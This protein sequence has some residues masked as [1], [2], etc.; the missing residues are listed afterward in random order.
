MPTQPLGEELGLNHNLVHYDLTVFGN[1]DSTDQD[2]YTHQL[3][4]APYDFFAGIIELRQDWQNSD[5]KVQE[6]VICG[7]IQHGF[8]KGIRQ[9][10]AEENPALATIAAIA[11]SAHIIGRLIELFRWAV[12]LCGRLIDSNA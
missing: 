4:E 9:A 8:H 2:T 10:L 3:P 11:I 7:N 6:I 1:H 5:L 12:G